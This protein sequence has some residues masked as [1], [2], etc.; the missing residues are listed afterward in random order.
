MSKLRYEQTKGI[1]HISHIHNNDGE[2]VS[3]EDLTNKPK[4]DNIKHYAAPII[5][6]GGI[7]YATTHKCGYNPIVQCTSETHVVELDITILDSGDILWASNVEL[8]ENDIARII[9]YGSETLND[10]NDKED[11]S[12]Y[13]CGYEWNVNDS[14]PAVTRITGEGLK[15]YFLRDGGG[16]LK[17]T[18]FEYVA[19]DAETGIETV[20]PI[21][22]PA[23][24]EN[25]RY[26]QHGDLFAKM[27]G[28][29]YYKVERE[30]DIRRKKLSRYP[31]P[32]F[33]PYHKNDYIVY[34]GLYEASCNN[35]RTKIYSR[36]T[37]ENEYSTHLGGYIV[38]AQSGSYA[39]DKFHNMPATYLSTS[40]FSN[41]AHSKGEGY[42]IMDYMTWLM[43]SD[44]FMAEFGTRNSQAPL[45]GADENDYSQGGLGNGCS[46]VSNWEAYVNT[47]PVTEIGCTDTHGSSCGQSLVPACTDMGLTPSNG[48]YANRYYGIENPFGHIFKLLTGIH[49]ITKGNTTDSFEYYKTFIC[50]DPSKFMIASNRDNG[51]DDN[52]IQFEAGYD[53]EGEKCYDNGYIKDVIFGDY[54]SMIPSAVGGNSSIH[55]SDTHISHN[56]EGSYFSGLHW[57]SFGGC[58]DYGPYSG[59]F[60]NISYNSW[61]G[62]SRKYGTRLCYYHKDYTTQPLTIT[63]NTNSEN[64]LT[65]KKNHASAPDVSVQYSFDLTTW[66]AMPTPTTT[67]SSI[68]IPAGGKIYLK[69]NNSG[70]SSIN[71]DVTRR[72]FNTINCSANFDVSGNIMSLLYGDDF[73]GQ[74]TLINK[75]TFFGLFYNSNVVSTEYLY[76]PA[77]QLTTYCYREMFSGCIKLINT[78]KIL[79]N[80]FAQGCYYG[81]Y[82]GTNILPDCSMINFEDITT[83]NSGVCIGLFQGTN[84]TDDDLFEILPINPSTNRYYLPIQFTNG[85]VY[86]YMF[87][88]CK[89]LQA[90][91][92]LPAITLTSNCYY[93]MF[94][95]CTSLINITKL[96]FM[97]TATC[98]C[99]SMF[100]DC[101]SLVNA[102]ELPATILAEEC[103]DAMFANCTSLV[104][105]PTKLP[106]INLS[107]YCYKSMFGDCTSLVNAPKIAGV[108]MATDCCMSMYLGCTSLRNV[109]NFEATQLADGCF[110]GMFE[111]CI[112]LVNAPELPATEL[113]YRCYRKLFKGCTSLVN[114]PEL[115]AT[116]LAKEC[117]YEM[118]AN[119]TSLNRISAGFTDFSNT[120]D[121][122]TN[123]VGGVASAGTMVLRTDTTWDGTR[124]ANS[125]PEGWNVEEYIPD[126]FYVEDCSGEANTLTITKS[127]VNAPDVN[128]EYSYDGK[129]WTAAPTTTV[130]GISIAVPANS[131]VYIRGVNATWNAYDYINGISEHRYN[132]INCA[133]NYNIGGNI[134]SVI[135]GIDF[136]NEN[137]YKNNRAMLKSMCS[138]SQ[139]LINAYKLRLPIK[140]SIV[141]T[142]YASMF[143]NCMNM[144]TAP[145]SIEAV[146]LITEIC[147]G[148]FVNCHALTNTPILNMKQD[149]T[150]G[151]GHSMYYFASGCS[152]ISEIKCHFQHYDNSNTQFTNWLYGVSP[153]GTF[154]LPYTSCFADDAPRN[155]HGIPAGWTIKY[156][157]PETGLE[158]DRVTEEELRNTY[159]YVEDISGEANTMMIKKCSND[160]S[161]L[162]AELADDVNL[163]YSY[164]MSTWKSLPTTNTTGITVSIPG[165]GRVYLRGINDKFSHIVYTADSTQFAVY[166]NVTF[167]NAVSI[168]GNLKSLCFGNNFTTAEYTNGEIFLQL[169]KD[170]I[171]IKYTHNLYIQTDARNGSN[172]YAMFTNCTG[173]ITP[174]I[175]KF[176]NGIVRGYECAKMFR[177]CTSLIKTFEL[178]D[179]SELRMYGLKET[180]YGCTS[181]KSTGNLSNI[182]SIDNSGCSGMFMNCTHLTEAS[183]FTNLTM[184]GDHGCYQMF[185]NCSSLLHAPNMNNVKYIEK[186]GCYAMYQSCISLTTMG[187]LDSLQTIND[188][189][190]GIMYHD[191]TNLVS[192]S[193]MDSL[194][195][196]GHEGCRNMFN[197]CTSMTI[198]PS[199]NSLN[200]IAYN[201]CY[202][203]FYNCKKLTSSVDLSSITELSASGCNS[204][205]QGCSKLTLAR[206]LPGIDNIPELGYYY[207]FEG[208]SELVEAPEILSTTNV[209]DRGCAGMF[210]NC[211]K[212]NYVKT[213]F[214]T[215]NANSMSNWLLNVASEG[216][217]IVSTN[218]TFTENAPRNGDGIPDG[219]S[220]TKMNF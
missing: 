45:M 177:S 205:F 106:A 199:M 208:C 23:E 149:K 29:L 11:Y 38:D 211:H 66:D 209:E 24:Y 97:Y 100:A 187:S 220:I 10:I 215:Y 30:G 126:Y 59:L 92:E 129:G 197:L 32:G 146:N 70:W 128:V 194:V 151:Y 143:R 63:N 83:I 103:Y 131:K 189:G 140:T 98:C 61:S 179:I 49:F 21:D 47:N 18:L 54:G 36:V 200:S 26:G 2:R 178:G 102:P 166:N 51:N 133:K 50:D 5:G 127:D 27:K 46:N 94:R 180:F 153:T 164:D 214:E 195:S 35:E 91:P 201:G 161:G 160:S 157:D 167:T 74:D 192:I 69:G 41:I 76:M 96:E 155:E 191:C 171:N 37:P 68:V 122:L 173:L 156:F 185:M 22:D 116:T 113:V 6:S 34:I 60:C 28:Q 72:Y 114:V 213:K 212:L 183:D 4:I 139:T 8:T 158:R 53:Y 210:A 73:I 15:D 108:I 39:V 67:G 145:Q 77:K 86:Q 57:A 147:S 154:W 16:I 120:Q 3:Y 71:S 204:M 124:S 181:L 81:M 174:P 12:Q 159:F 84:V 43:L 40:S 25:Y 118:F 19:H 130:D 169:F 219:W 206:P 135:H 104:N 88:H 17:G 165:N 52:N 117:Y 48:V 207:M 121:E 89:K 105:A 31:L 79:A 90:T 62:S 93:E 119:C 101:T 9:V 7:I 13:W 123:W 188:Y 42:D 115:P 162:Y 138:Y 190:C 137:K 217:F 1:S 218:S 80:S 172:Y 142:I 170:S 202:A 141:T 132:T 110:R 99:G 55:F 144:I 33:K 112:S 64:T 193:N 85:A 196:I 168:G 216:Q 107:D 203:M 14:D 182:Q 134:M 65:I 82:D 175:M 163:E 58:S 87:K 56:S 176:K 198:A 109:P 75:C 136:L 186:Y 78:P 44:L 111:N 184:I 125:V 152:N 20:V 150:T 95:G 148:M